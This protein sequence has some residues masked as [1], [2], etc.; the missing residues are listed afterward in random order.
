M[1]D[2]IKLYLKK[3]DW[4][5][6]FS[7]IFLIAFGLVEIYSIS[8]GQGELDS[9]N[10]KK[11]LFFSSI[12]IL[13]LFIFTFVDAYFLKSLS[14]YWY[15]LSILILVF[16][17]IFG[18]E[19]RGTKGWFYIFGFGIQPVEL[20]KVSLIIILATYFSGLSSK[21]KTFRHF[22][23]S[24]FLTS[25]L[26]VLVL[27]QPDF[28]SA[29]ML[30]AIWLIMMLAAGFS[31]KYFISLFLVGALLSSMA[32][33]L[34]FQ[35]Y[36][37][38][39]IITF[40]NPSEAA[41]ESGYNVNQA[42]IAI[43]SGGIAGKGVGFGS[44]SQLKFLPEAQNDFIF[45]VI[46][47]ELGFLGV[48]LVVLFYSVFFFRGLTILPK[49]KDDFGVYLI[50][51]ALGLIFIQMFINIGMNIGIVPIVGLSLPFVSY[52]GSALLS[53]LVLVGIMENIIIKSKINY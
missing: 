4:I 21:F 34:F 18:Q 50:I 5:I 46:A 35:D 19:F 26:F 17:L 48:S 40:L 13:L 31:K 16:V 47:E 30:F 23:I 12:G 10:F 7:V 8:L 51:G 44:Q 43:G 2:K 6:F 37:K 1:L 36:Q 41:L 28:G 49:I 29:M 32:W 24:G 14:K 42:M 27:L 22:F 25:V 33:F 39:R 11:Q 15:L 9:L 45:S 3:F 20:V 38:D 53:L 52:G